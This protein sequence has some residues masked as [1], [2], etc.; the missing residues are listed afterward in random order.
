M[1]RFHTYGIELEDR[2][3]DYAEAILGYPDVREFLDASRS[4]PWLM[5]HN[6]LDI[7]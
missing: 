2:P 6:E 5:A 4:E 7:D 1:C 3:C